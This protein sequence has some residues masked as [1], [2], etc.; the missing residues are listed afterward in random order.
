[1]AMSWNTQFDQSKILFAFA[2]AVLLV[3]LITYAVFRGGAT[4][5]HVLPQV[6]ANEFE[7]S[8]LKTDKPVLVDFYAEWCG[9]CKKMEPILAEFARENPNIKVV[10]V[11][12]DDNTDLARS[13]EITAV[14]TLLLFRKGEM[15]GESRG[16]LSEEGLTKF[17]DEPAKSR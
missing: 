14:P 9:P 8:V 17:V 4:S 1:M 12:V 11:N 7:S 15:V 16:M 13:Y 2:G 3:L 6:R 10:Q 5:E